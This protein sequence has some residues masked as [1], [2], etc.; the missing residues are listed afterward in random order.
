MKILLILKEKKQDF[1]NFFFF[2]LIFILFILNSCVSDRYQKNLI[3]PTTANIYDYSKKIKLLC[4]DESEPEFLATLSS[5]SLPMNVKFEGLWSNH[6]NN[7]YGNIL[8]LTGDLIYSF[9]IDSDS[10]H[11]LFASNPEIQKNFKEIIPH[12]TPHLLRDLTCGGYSLTENNIFYFQN[13]DKNKFIQNNKIQTNNIKLNV[14]SIYET[15][16]LKTGTKLEIESELEYS[17]ILYSKKINLNWKS[18]I[19]GDKIYVQSL[20]LHG[21]STDIIQINFD[22]FN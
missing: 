16:S 8:S 2:H 1:K 9:Q 12:L 11:V 6:F 7:F 19:D 3:A 13:Q 15:L 22:E 4:S 14:N 10:F 20:V 17:S 5:K 21:L 18:R